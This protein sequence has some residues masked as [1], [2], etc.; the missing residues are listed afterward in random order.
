MQRHSDQRQKEKQ[1]SGGRAFKAP[2]P[3]SGNMSKTVESTKPV[4]TGV[5]DELKVWPLQSM[6]QGNSLGRTRGMDVYRGGREKHSPALMLF[7]GEL[8]SLAH[9]PIPGMWDIGGA[10]LSLGQLPVCKAPDEGTQSL[11]SW[12]DPEDRVEDLGTDEGGYTPLLVFTKLISK[13]ERQ[14]KV[15]GISVVQKTFP[16]A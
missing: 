16:L 8:A 15:P 1:K 12:K 3:F 6:F 14:S 7:P 5:R 10:A 11:L 9:A 4:D 2:E 13:V